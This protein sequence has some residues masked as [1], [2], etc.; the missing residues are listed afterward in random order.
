[1]PGTTEIRP[2][3]NTSTV[4]DG[5][6]GIFTYL[7]PLPVVE[8]NMVFLKAG[9]LRGEHFHKEFHEFFLVIAGKGLYETWDA[10]G[11]KT[12]RLLTGGELLHV[13]PGTPHVLHAIEDMTCV[14]LLTKRWDDCAEPITAFA[15][16]EL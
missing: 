3:C 8:A 5:R 4:V 7:L 16:E 6:G 15:A 2:S 12:Q 10:A 9:K 14:A 1:M 13:S 11:N